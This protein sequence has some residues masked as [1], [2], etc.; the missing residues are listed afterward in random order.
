[1]EQCKPYQLISEKRTDS[2][3]DCPWNK[4]VKLS[5]YENSKKKIFVEA[6]ELFRRKRIT[7]DQSSEGKPT[8]P[9]FL[10]TKN[11]TIAKCV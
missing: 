10:I 4:F 6:M 8:H 3:N 5:R 9:A 7:L 1:M 11:M 2:I